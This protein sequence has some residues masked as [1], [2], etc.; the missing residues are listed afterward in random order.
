M[1]IINENKWRKWAKKW[2]WNDNEE[3]NNEEVIMKK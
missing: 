2:K 1:K 3:I